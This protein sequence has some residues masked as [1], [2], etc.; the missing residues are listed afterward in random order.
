[1]AKVPTSVWI[2]MAI[3]YV[4]LFRVIGAR[5]WTQSVLMAIGYTLSFILVQIVVF[6]TRGRRRATPEA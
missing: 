5:T 1:M 3:L 6:K 4:P 2:V